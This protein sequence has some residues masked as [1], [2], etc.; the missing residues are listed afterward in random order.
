[1]V[2]KSK[3]MVRIDLEADNIGNAVLQNERAFD[4]SSLQEELW[5]V[6]LNGGHVII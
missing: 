4:C 5:A 2:V 3:E 6:V 1:M